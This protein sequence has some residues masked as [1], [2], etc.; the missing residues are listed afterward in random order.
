VPA[1]NSPGRILNGPKIMSTDG[2]R[3]IGELP[4]IVVTA[5]QSDDTAYGLTDGERPA[6]D[7][8]W[9]LNSPSYIERFG[10]GVVGAI[11]GVTVEPVLQVRDLAMAG[12]SVVYNE[13]IRSKNDSLWLPEM[14]SGI[15]EQYSHGASQSRLL[16]QSNF[17]TGTGVLSYDATTALIHGQYGDLA[18]MAG[19]IV[20][21]FA[22]GKATQKY[23]AYG[24]TIEDIGATGPLASQRGSVGLK[25]VGGNNAETRGSFPTDPHELTNM[26]GTQPKKIGLTPDGTQRIV[27]EPN[28]NTRIRFESHPEGLQSGDVGFNP[29]HHG[30]HFHIELKPDGVSWNNASK[31]GLIIKP[32]PKG[33]TPGSGKGFLPGE[34]FPGY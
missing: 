24:I 6:S 21:G 20:G 10:N 25:L 32:E 8:K 30:E 12:A 5:N 26:L 2:I 15:A 13:V 19:G 31:N 11:K 17:V 28:A 9:T 14:K 33:Y 1:R 34:E 23:G 27:W 16:L 3:D 4:T 29:R 7:L 22:L 18:E